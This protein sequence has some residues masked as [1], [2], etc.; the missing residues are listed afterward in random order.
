[1]YMCIYV[2]KIA[3]FDWCA[4]IIWVIMHVRCESVC[5]KT[6]MNVCQINSTQVY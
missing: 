3:R 2:T 1:M 5:T 4:V 6:C